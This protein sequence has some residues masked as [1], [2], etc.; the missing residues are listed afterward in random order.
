MRANACGGSAMVKASAATPCYDTASGEGW[1]LL[2]TEHILI[3][4]G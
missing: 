4:I 2:T 3:L 1:L